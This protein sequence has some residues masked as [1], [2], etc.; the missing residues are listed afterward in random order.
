MDQNF[1]PTPAPTGSPTTQFEY[2]T[3][4]P[5]IGSVVGLLVVFCLILIGMKR[6]ADNEHRL[7]RQRRVHAAE[8]ERALERAKTALARSIPAL[9]YSTYLEY[10]STSK[11][12]VEADEGEEA[13]C[14][15]CLSDFDQISGEVKALKCRH[16]YYAACLDQWLRRSDF[17]PMCKRAAEPVALEVDKIDKID[18][19]GG[20]AEK[21][22]E[23][24]VVVV[25][26][27]ASATS[28]TS[29]PL[30]TDPRREAPTAALGAATISGTN[31]GD[32]LEAGLV[33]LDDGADEPEENSPIPD[34]PP[35]ENPH[36]S[37]IYTRGQG[38]RLDSVIGP[39]Q[40]GVSP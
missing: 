1:F 22:G 13:C 31:S 30:P 17:C 39:S 25:C 38:T 28:P 24:G 34:R 27:G 37:Y 33:S 32:L 23:G 4:L 20:D 26:G 29:R 7:L 11:K 14:P 5:F 2:S 19:A 6:Y 21:G 10:F 40:D 16:V 9:S 18:K 36:A 3:K 15:V 8:S 12:L 35:A